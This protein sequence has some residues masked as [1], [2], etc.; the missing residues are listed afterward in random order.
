[1]RSLLFL[2]LILSLLFSCQLDQ[3]KL[4]ID[5]K[6][7]SVSS[8]NSLPV[9][10]VLLY[11][12]IQRWPIDTIL[13]ALADINQV[14]GNIEQRHAGYSLWKVQSDTIEDYRYLIQGHWPDQSSYD[15][16]H[17][18]PD[19]R[20]ALDKNIHIFTETRKWD[21]YRRYELVQ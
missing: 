4:N 18:N 14:V 21:L 3:P 10:S 1:M 5:S 19:F 15:S 12:T 16:I 7:V 17:V 20:K 11:D 8:T 9:K 2:L 6:D 13:S